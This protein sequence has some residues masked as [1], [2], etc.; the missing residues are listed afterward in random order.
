MGEI[1]M[2]DGG[3]VSTARPKQKHY[4]WRYLLVW[5]SG[6]ISCIGLIVGGVLITGMVMKTRDV[7]YMVGLDPNQYIG[8][9]YQ[10]KTILQTVTTLAN[11][12]F[13]TL[14]DL[15]Q[16]SPMVETL[17]EQINDEY[18]EPTLSFRFSWEE[19]KNKPFEKKSDYGTKNGYEVDTSTT[20]T[21][22]LADTAL[23]NV[24][25]ANFIN[26]ADSPQRKILE[27]FLYDVQRDEEG[28]VIFDTDGN[29]VLGEPY[30]LKDFMNKKEDKG[31]GVSSA[32][33]IDSGDVENNDFFQ[34]I[35]DN[36]F[37]CA[38][39]SYLGA[40][41]DD[42]DV[43]I[44]LISNYTFR[45]IFDGALNDLTVGQFVG[46][47]GSNHLLAR[48]FA[49]TI[50]ELNDFDFSNATF[51][52]LLMI[53]Y[54]YVLDGS[55]NPVLY[56]GDGIPSPVY[57]EK[58][59][60]ISKDDISPL[61]LRTLGTFKTN[62]LG[63]TSFIENLKINQFIEIDESSPKAMR[64]LGNYSF[65]QIAAE[66]FLDGLYFG[67][68]FDII[69]D[70]SNSEY[71]PLMEKLATYKLGDIKKNSTF[72][73]I[74]IGDL[75]KREEHTGDKLIIALLDLDEAEKAEGREGVNLGN[76]S[77]M[78]NSIQLG[79]ILDLGD[80]PTR[81]MQTVAT[82]TLLDIPNLITQLTVRDVM[83][84][85]VGSYYKDL[86]TNDIY[87]KNENSVWAILDKSQP[88]LT[89]LDKEKIDRDLAI[90]DNLKN[91]TDEFEGM[92][93]SFYEARLLSG[94]GA[95]SSSIGITRG[96][97][98]EI[99]N[100]SVSDPGDFV[101]EIK[102]R[103][104][105]GALVE[106]NDDSP[107][108]LQNLASCTLN[109]VPDKL[110]KMA[111]HD[112]LEIASPGQEGYS[113]ILYSL[114]NAVLFD[115]ED[116]NY[117]SNILHTLKLGD[118]LEI[119]NSSPMILQTLKDFYIDGSGSDSLSN[120]DVM[121]F[122]FNQL[123]TYAEVEAQNDALLT[124]LWG[125]PSTG[126]NFTVSQLPDR[127]KSIRLTTLIGGDLYEDASKPDDE[128]QLKTVWWFLFTSEEDYKGT[129]GYNST[130]LD[131][132]HYL[133]NLLSGK[134]YNSN[135]LVNLVANLSYHMQNEKL[136]DLETA[137]LITTGIDLTQPLVINTPY[138]PY[139]ITSLPAGEY[140][141]Q[142]L[143]AFFS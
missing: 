90:Y 63:D 37:D 60:L 46:D 78:V 34:H 109:E 57:N 65:H 129:G 127:V 80:N 75:F 82:K 11:K 18:V 36:V 118:V 83:D 7:M 137:G 59:Q 15:N 72:M 105:L 53:Q 107:L 101:S 97:L 138:G 79:S 43:V 24:K 47:D 66:G 69:T 13:D 56:T 70:P 31:S 130:G 135:N 3:S 17:F 6:V 124:E 41:I 126:G 132:G 5:F 9:E 110:M 54:P 26:I 14:E 48:L 55:G 52:Q 40:N 85:E 143:F 88:G 77:T 30:S 71:S 22:Y 115:S 61:F 141:I 128:K 84:I 142:D 76:I 39:L 100:V 102:L 32:P 87:F 99:R 136:K 131:A 23:T 21:E 96:T 74:S 117:I 86:D 108:V 12:S 139:A 35:I 98:F 62:Q 25:I 49:M 89:D 112:I 106:I 51:A 16:V 120:L 114:R 121:S 140:T 68:L 104:K 29:P 27:L 103:M 73:N 92:S 50:Q 81:L 95:P 93:E 8:I 28:K 91:H 42:S 45:Q 134:E 20:L 33:V 44:K 94:H 111:L 38:T 64:T 123:M 113:K 4:W 67:E 122:K 2:K 19:T 1:R 125:D 119:S 133:K 10:D 116:P 58:G